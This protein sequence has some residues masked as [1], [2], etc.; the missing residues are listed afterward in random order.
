MSAL[1]IAS[2]NQPKQSY[3]PKW[4]QHW[5]FPLLPIFEIYKANHCNAGDFN[6]HWLFLKVNSSMVPELEFQLTLDDMGLRA[7]IGLPYVR[8]HILLLPFPQKWYQKYWRTG[9]PV[10]DKWAQEAEERQ[11]IK[12]L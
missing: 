8:I 12:I 6:F 3:K 2:D 11:K 1:T 4:Y 5:R 9:P 7:H 10:W